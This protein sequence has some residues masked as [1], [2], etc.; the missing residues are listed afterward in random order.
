MAGKVKAKDL[1]FKAK[2]KAAEF[3]LK[4]NHSEF[5]YFVLWSTCISLFIIRMLVF[6]NKF[7]NKQ[8]DILMRP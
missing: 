6:W 1:F 3:D 7:I 8:E 5:F 4:A 2:V